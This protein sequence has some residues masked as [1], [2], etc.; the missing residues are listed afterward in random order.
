MHE[1]YDFQLLDNNDPSEI[2]EDAIAT[3]PSA[4]IFHAS[5]WLFFIEKYFKLKLK[6]VLIFKNGDIKGVF[7]FFEKKYGFFKI[8]G[9]PMFT[10][11]N[12]YTGFAMKNHEEIEAILPAIEKFLRNQGIHFFRAQFDHFLFKD[13]FIKM[14]YTIKEFPSYRMDLSVGEEILW[15]GIGQKGRNLVRKAEKNNMQVTE[16]YD[17]SF[18]DTYY[19]MSKE[20]YARHDRLPFFE[21]SYYIDL[22]NLLYNDNL[23]RI[24]TVRSKEG[25]TVA[26][27]IILIYQDKAYYL[28]GVSFR[29][30][31]PLGINNFLQWTIIKNL[32]SADVKIYDMD[33]AGTLGLIKF[34]KSFGTVAHPTLYAEKP[35]SVAARTTRLLYG[36]FLSLQ[37]Y[38]ERYLVRK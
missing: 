4:T 29:K 17:T 12:P 28:S 5:D 35:Y 31:Q 16:V 37:T 9:S 36:K 25:I 26:G 2:W 11:N 3:I 33:T 23:G 8:A 14:G 6:R 18:I 30:Y 24:Y 15:K 34:K 20:V 7:P 13:N 1:T 27:A 22:C 32:K 10:R 21:K 38:L 19:K